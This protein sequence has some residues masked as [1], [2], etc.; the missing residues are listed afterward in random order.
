MDQGQRDVWGMYA[1]Y[2]EFKWRK[3]GQKLSL[4]DILLRFSQMTLSLCG[5]GRG[6]TSFLTRLHGHRAW[7]EI[8][9]TSPHQHLAQPTLP[10]PAPSQT[11]TLVLLW[12]R[13]TT[14]G[15]GG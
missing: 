11:P 1:P 14:G 2:L 10:H 15:G 3:K 5:P 6:S 9:I 8:T 4:D 12:Q 13:L 7:K